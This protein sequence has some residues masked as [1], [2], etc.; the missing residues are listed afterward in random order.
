[1]WATLRDWRN[2]FR[3]LSGAQSVIFRSHTDAE[4]YYRAYHGAL[5]PVK[6]HILPNGFEGEVESF[7]PTHGE[8][9]EFLYT[10]TLSEYRYDTLLQA[11][12][13]LKTFYPVEAAQMHFHFV[14]EGTEIIGKRADTLGLKDVITTEGAISQS[15]VVELSKKAHA[16]LLLGRPAVM[17]GYE[18][19]AAAKL[20]G[21]LKAGRPIVGILPSDEAK[22]I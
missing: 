18:L 11:I 5:E 2:L 15:A 1:R 16:L 3:L 17:K 22:Q 19:F 13:F 8:K 10:G 9:C 14:G 20:F 4:C 6:I 21:Y 7:D 12:C